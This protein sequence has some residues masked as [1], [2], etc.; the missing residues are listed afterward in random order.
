MRRADQ[1]DRDLEGFVSDDFP[2][3]LELAPVGQVQLDGFSVLRV[4][5]ILQQVTRDQSLHEHDLLSFECP[6]VDSD[7][8]EVGQRNGDGGSD[9]HVFG[10]CEVVDAEERDGKGSEVNAVEEVEAPVL[11]VDVLVVVLHELE[12]NEAKQGDE[13]ESEDGPGEDEVPDRELLRER[14]GLGQGEDLEEDGQVVEHHVL[15]HSALPCT[16]DTGPK[17]S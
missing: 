4:C 2:E 15:G 8:R 6:Q 1:E 7:E 3:A 17:R 12:E 14:L 5:Q 11:A 9:A 16:G 10:A 13:T